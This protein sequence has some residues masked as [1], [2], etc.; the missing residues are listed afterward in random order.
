[1]SVRGGAQYHPKL[2]PLSDTKRV[3]S[4]YKPYLYRIRSRNQ[5][6][7]AAFRLL[8]I[9]FSLPKTTFLP[10]IITSYPVLSKYLSLSSHL[11]YRSPLHQKAEPPARSHTCPCRGLCLVVSLL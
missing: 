7:K 5:E 3:R 1:M 9:T 6:R 2:L 4:V 10:L 8:I 11:P